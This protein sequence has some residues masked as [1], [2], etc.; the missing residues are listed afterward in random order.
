MAQEYLYILLYN[1][2]A[3]HGPITCTLAFDKIDVPESYVRNAASQIEVWCEGPNCDWHGP[4]GAL[5]F[6]RMH[7]GTWMP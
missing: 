5:N 1:C 7:V 4:A 6:V 3:C 2:N